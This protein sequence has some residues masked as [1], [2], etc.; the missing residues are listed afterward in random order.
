MRCVVCVS[1]VNTDENDD[2]CELSL[3]RACAMEFMNSAAAAEG[4]GNNSSDDDDDDD[5]ETIDFRL[6]AR[7][8]EGGARG[9]A[10]PAAADED[11]IAPAAAADAD[12][13][14]ACNGSRSAGLS[15]DREG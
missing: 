3:V 4:G 6:G 13:I 7:T 9:D 8:R 2:Q 11:S 10:E 5:D 1:S 12:E 14:D 15:A